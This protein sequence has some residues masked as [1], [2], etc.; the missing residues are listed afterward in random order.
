MNLA[1]ETSTFLG[2]ALCACILSAYVLQR[3]WLAA[4]WKRG[5][6]ALK[7]RDFAAVNEAFHYIVKK[8]PGW[9]M[10]RR[11]LARGLAGVGRHD[12]AEREFRLAAQLEPRNPEGHIDLAVFL[13][14]VAPERREEALSCIEAALGVAPD[15]RTA[16]ATLPQLR[17]LHSHP[18]F[19]DLAGL[20]SLD[21]PPSR[22]N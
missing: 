19:R 11:M 20:P 8:R 12:E 17:P 2:L 7:G 5:M 16:I 4:A 13:V 21:V 9:A 22:L 10:A 18:R 1:P 14:S 6:E 3:R 15:L